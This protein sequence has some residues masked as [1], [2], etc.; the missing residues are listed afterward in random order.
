MSQWELTKVN[1]LNVIVDGYDDTVEHLCTLFDAQLN[2]PIPGK[3]DEPDETDACLITIG[4][5]IFELFAP[6]RRG[7]RGQGRLLDRFGDHYIGIEYKV[8]DVEAARQSCADLDIRI[9][10]DVGRFF[11]THPGSCL[12]ISWE[13]WDGDWH[14]ILGTEGRGPLH[15]RSYWREEHPLHLDGLR[16]IS[17]AVH[18]LDPAIER[19]RVLTGAPVIGRAE[20]PQAV[21]IGAELQV[22]DT[23]FELLAPTGPGPVAAYLD[24]YG[25]RI[26]STVFATTDLAAVENHL[27]TKGITLV[28]G[29]REDT[30]AIPPEQNH[31]L[32]FEFTE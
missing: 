20:R 13:L 27:G 14:A 5:V 7:E 17:V 15:P 16:R 11:L 4:D 24:R 25:E 8:P 22:G 19:L 30:R 3:P 6:R 1:H 28:P 29:D 12:G 10:N 18:D 9:I 32:L 21:S 26:R 23:V 31:N 2:L